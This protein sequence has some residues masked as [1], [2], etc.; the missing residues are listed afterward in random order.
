MTL[1]FTLFIDRLPNFHVDILRLLSEYR[2]IED[3][4]EDVTNHGNSVLVQK[5]FHLIKNNEK[6]LVTDSLIYTSEIIDKILS[7]EHFDSVTYRLVLPNTCYNWHFD[8]GKI[9][10]HIPLIT[11]PGCRFVYDT[12]AFAMPSDGSVYVVNNSIH[13]SF[14]NAGSEPRL[15]LTFENL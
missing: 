11:N 12:K 15:H 6:N 8:T 1:P 3:R 9:C 5:K 2:T 14:M 10:A 13:H 4:M 7:I